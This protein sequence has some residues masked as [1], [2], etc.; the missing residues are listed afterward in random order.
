MSRID[1]CVLPSKTLTTRVI[2]KR[3]KDVRKAKKQN[4]LCIGLRPL[5]RPKAYTAVCAQVHGTKKKQRIQKR[6]S[7]V[8]FPPCPVTD[9]DLVPRPRAEGKNALRVRRFIL[10]TPKERVEA[11]VAESLEEPLDVGSR[12]SA[13]GVETQ[14]RV[15]HHHRPA[16]LR[17]VQ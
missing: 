5:P 4:G 9:L 15:F 17:V 7:V 14:P 8:P 3:D 16:H 1:P 2:T 10:E 12:Q 11:V 6:K 13:E